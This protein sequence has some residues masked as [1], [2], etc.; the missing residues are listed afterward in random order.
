MAVILLPTTYNLS[1]KIN[2]NCTN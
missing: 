1:L 2:I